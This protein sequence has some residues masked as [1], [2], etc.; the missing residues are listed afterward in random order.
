MDN[1]TEEQIDWNKLQFDSLAITPCDA[2]DTAAFRTTTT[3]DYVARRSRLF[4]TGH[5]TLE[6]ENLTKAQFFRQNIQEI[7]DII[8]AINSLFNLSINVRL[9][10]EE[11]LGVCNAEIGLKA[12][13]I[14]DSKHN[15]GAGELG[16]LPLSSIHRYVTGKDAPDPTLLYEPTINFEEFLIYLGGL[17]TIAEYDMTY[18]YPGIAGNPNKQAHNAGAVVH[19]YFYSPNYKPS[20]SKPSNT[21][22]LTS[23]VNDSIGEL[24]FKSTFKASHALPSRISNINEGIELASILQES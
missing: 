1:H 15:H 4:G 2:L 24:I 12:G 10:L 13:G 14:I 3:H 21:T 22:I 18:L 7:H 17:K 19:G 6:F 8:E 5:P 16:L 11:V 20:S 23:I 9:T